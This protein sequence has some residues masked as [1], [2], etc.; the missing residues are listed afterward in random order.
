MG[1]LWQDRNSVVVFI[2]CHWWNIYLSY[3]NTAFPVLNES[4]L[5]VWS[6]RVELHC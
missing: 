5:D 3:Q 1:I 6:Y 2:T 4:L